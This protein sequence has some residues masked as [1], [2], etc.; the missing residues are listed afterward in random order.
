M[1][2]KDQEQLTRYRSH[3]SIGTRSCGK[4]LGSAAAKELSLGFKLSHG[5]NTIG[6]LHASTLE[7]LGS[8]SCTGDIM[9]DSDHSMSSSSYSPPPLVE[10]DATSPSPPLGK[11]NGDG[12]DDDNLVD[13]SPPPLL[14]ETDAT[15]PPPLLDDNADD[16]DDV[17]DLS[18]PPLLSIK[19][20]DS[21][22]DADICIIG[23]DVVEEPCEKKK[24]SPPSFAMIVHAARQ[25]Q[26]VTDNHASTVPPP[27][28][29]S[30]STP[31]PPTVLHKDHDVV[32]TAV[33]TQTET[34][35]LQQ[36]LYYFYC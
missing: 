30:T 9:S 13:L 2:E 20:S 29:P 7:R 1:S 22:S 26:L 16:D 12:E 36:L 24:T 17:D 6:L 3:S 34:Q 33:M 4:E 27:P 25:F 23:L 32:D 28:S 10:F 35:L 31:T 14:M 21:D 18:P 19:Y 5:S 11:D 15:S 8:V